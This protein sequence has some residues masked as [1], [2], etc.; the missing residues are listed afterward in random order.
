MNVRFQI[1]EVV[2]RHYLHLS[3]VQ[4][5]ASGEDETPNPAKSLDGNLDHHLESEPTA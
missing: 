4:L 5:P 1:A 3:R 2:D